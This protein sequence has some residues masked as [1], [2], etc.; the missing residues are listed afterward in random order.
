MKSRG[1]KFR[2]VGLVCLLMPLYKVD[3]TASFCACLRSTQVGEESV[4]VIRPYKRI[5]LISETLLSQESTPNVTLHHL[6]R[7]I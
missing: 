1:V 6:L 4:N 2:S 5:H 7:R 3:F